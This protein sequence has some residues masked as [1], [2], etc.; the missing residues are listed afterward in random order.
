MTLPKLSAPQIATLLSL[1]A[2]EAAGL[3]EPRLITHDPALVTGDA[4]DHLTRWGSSDQMRYDAPFKC[5][6]PGLRCQT[7]VVLNTPGVACL[8]RRP[9]RKDPK[10]WMSA[11]AAAFVLTAVG[12][13]A[14]VGFAR[15][16][17][18]GKGSF[19][20]PIWF[21]WYRRWVV[22]GMHAFKATEAHRADAFAFEVGSRHRALM[23]RDGAAYE[24]GDVEL[25][26]NNQSEQP[27][28]SFRDGCALVA[29]VARVHAAVNAA[30]NAAPAVHR[31]LLTAWVDRYPPIT[32][33]VAADVEAFAS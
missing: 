14:A 10:A 25:E 27:S 4:W 13:R 18:A 5:P 23:E 3:P 24:P 2:A 30:W 1:A 7:L 32:G 28:M 8:D 33:D 9:A 6:L 26:W 16:A 19:E 11:D 22:E 17:L 29:R 31:D 20:M 12:R 15:E 21:P